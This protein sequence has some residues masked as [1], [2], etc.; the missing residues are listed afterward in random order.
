M[1][2]LLIKASFRPVFS[3]C[4]SSSSIF[5]TRWS[6]MVNLGKTNTSLR[7][8]WAGILYAVMLVH[9]VTLKLPQVGGFEN[10][11]LSPIHQCTFSTSKPIPELLIIST[12]KRAGRFSEKY[13]AVQR[14][15]ALCF[16]LNL[17]QAWLLSRPKIPVASSSRTGFRV[18]FPLP[19]PPFLLC[20]FHPPGYLFCIGIPTRWN[21]LVT[22]MMAVSEELPS[23]SSRA[24]AR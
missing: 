3:I 5:S 6:G 15:T 24:S 13:S 10:C 1:A 16:S 9:R 17:L 23:N 22:A 11:F 18:W 19:V 20:R 7:V 14:E 21:N 4:F 2:S 8:V 12:T